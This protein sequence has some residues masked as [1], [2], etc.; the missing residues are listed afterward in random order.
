MSSVMRA[1]ITAILLALVAFAACGAPAL[2]SRS[3]VGE[4]PTAVPRTPTPQPAT[5]EEAVIQL[6]WSE[7]RAVVAKDIAALM[8]LWAPEA[9][10]VDAKHTPE[11]PE[12]DAR[13]RGRDAIRERY[14]VLVF[15][16]NPQSSAAQD[17]K[18]SFDG[19]RAIA[20]S[21]TA[22]GSEVSPGGDRWTFIRR[23]GRWWIESLTYNLEPAQ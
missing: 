9:T 5:D 19:D 11:K 13:W 16:G 14:V 22:I 18:L 3:T 21:T 6:V 7:G 8:D 1:L 20:V 17:L 4:K 15:P 23:D 2:P 10:I 12:D